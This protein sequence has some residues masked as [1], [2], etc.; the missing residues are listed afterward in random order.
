MDLS[1]S[2]WQR[3]GRWYLWISAV[4]FQGVLGYWILPHLPLISE[5]SEEGYFHYASKHYFPKN[6]RLLFRGSEA[7]FSGLNEIYVFSAPPQWIQ[8]ML[9]QAPWP[10][11]TWE[12][13]EVTG[14]GKFGTCSLP[15]EN[16]QRALKALLPPGRYRYAKKSDEFIKEFIINE[17]TGTVMMCASD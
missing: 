9:A 7:I 2:Q 1:A 16:D 5:F 11:A 17:Q 4:L 12:W 10:D 15:D 3:I 14:D 8:T 6:A 13:I